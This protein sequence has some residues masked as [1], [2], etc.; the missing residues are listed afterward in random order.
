MR[1]LWAAIESELLAILRA[2]T[3]EGARYQEGYEAALESGTNGTEFLIMLAESLDGMKMDRFR[4]AKVDDFDKGWQ[5]ACRE[6]LK[7]L[8]WTKEGINH[9]VELRDWQY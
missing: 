1:R 7:K 3:T 8:G 9:A 5:D 2:L 4:G 6:E